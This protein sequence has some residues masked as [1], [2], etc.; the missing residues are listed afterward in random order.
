MKD[1]LQF[2]DKLLMKGGVQWIR[3]EFVPTEEQE[4][5][6]GIRFDKDNQ[7]RIYVSVSSI[8]GSA[9]VSEEKYIEFFKK[10]LRKEIKV[11]RRTIKSD[12]LSSSIKKQNGYLKAVLG[13][14]E[15]LINSKLT[16]EESS[17]LKFILK[18]L[19]DDLITRYINEKYFRKESEQF[20]SFGF[21]VTEFEDED[22]KRFYIELNKLQPRGFVSID[23]TSVNSF[24]QTLTTKN[25]TNET[26]KIFLSCETTQAS[27][28][29]K[30]MQPYFKHFKY[31]D[32][33]KSKIFITSNEKP[34]TKSN[35]FAS[36][37][38]C[39]KPKDPDLIEQVFKEI[40]ERQKVK[41]S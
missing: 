17:V 31:S 22:L 16:V 32:I 15:F 13:E 5:Y 28:I 26:D 21:K 11:A 33:E 19:K 14:T 9:E 1:P 38:R 36:K 41:K 18:F 39:S 29:L 8:D 30:E 23:K 34:L 24:V 10:R 37:N 35:L 27:L 7:L 6:Q 40:K 12:Y 20:K 3:E 4:L 2:F 25:I